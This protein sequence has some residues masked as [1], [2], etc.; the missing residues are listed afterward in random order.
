MSSPTIGL[1]ATSGIITLGAWSNQD[2]IQIEDNV[3]MSC[4]N[5]SWMLV[6]KCY[7]FQC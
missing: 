3:Y 4:N 1:P 5:P 7:T 6:I 2:K